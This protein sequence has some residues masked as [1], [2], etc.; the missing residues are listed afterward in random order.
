[1]RLLAAL[2]ALSA[3]LL[4]A[5][6]NDNPVVLVGS[7]N[8][9]PGGGIY[10]FI[11]PSLNATNGT[12]IT[13]RFTGA[14]GNHTITQSTFADPCNPLPGGFDSGWVFIPPSNVSTAPEWNLTITNTSTPL[15]FFCKQLVPLTHCSAGMVGAINA[16]ASGNFTFDKY[17]T[18]ANAFKGPSGQGEGSLV[19]IGASASAGPG[20]AVSGA[21]FYTGAPVASGTAPSTPSGSGAPGG[22]T[23]QNGAVSMM[24]STSVV[25]AGVAVGALLGFA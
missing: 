22:G 12:T 8:G 14:P 9:A 1:M 4:A 20:P 13:F 11:P 16:P 10:Q 7:V 6:Q 15:W 2:S 19:G 5:A 21:T 17:K 3:T 25:M 24:V 18:N 23:N